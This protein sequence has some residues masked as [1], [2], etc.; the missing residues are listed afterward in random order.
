[1]KDGWTIKEFDYR[2]RKEEIIGIFDRYV[3]AEDCFHNK[4]W[5]HI[6]K[7]K[8]L[9]YWLEDKRIIFMD[10]SEKNVIDLWLL[11]S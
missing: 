6:L 7:D 10:R 2:T 3:E 9:I 4:K 11:P 5:E 8:L 1:M